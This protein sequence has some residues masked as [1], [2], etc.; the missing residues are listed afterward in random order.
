MSS[1]FICMSMG[2]PYAGPGGE[3]REAVLQLSTAR[4]AGEGRARVH[5]QQTT[6]LHRILRNRRTSVLGLLCG[7]A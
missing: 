7:R 4:A 2:E 5:E 1:A 6:R 3:T